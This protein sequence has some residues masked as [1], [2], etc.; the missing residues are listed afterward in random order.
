VQFPDLPTLC[1]V[2]DEAHQ[3]M[4]RGELFSAK[5]EVPTP[6]GFLGL[7]HALPT[8]E[9]LF[10]LDT[11]EDGSLA[12]FTSTENTQFLGAKR[13]RT[14]LVSFSEEDSLVSD[15]FSDFD[16]DLVT[17]DLLS[18]YDSDMSASED[19]ME[20]PKVNT[21]LPRRTKK[22]TQSEESD[23][24]Y[25]VVKEESPT[26]DSPSA[27]QTPAGQKHDNAITSSDDATTPATNQPQSR[28]GRKQSLTEDPSKTFVC[29]L[30]NRRFRR[31]EHLKRHYRSLHTGEKP[32]ECTDCGKKFSRSDN[33][34]QHQRTHGSGSIVMGVLESPHGFGG[35]IVDHAYPPPHEM[36]A[37]MLN[38]ALAAQQNYPSSASS[39]SS[40]SDRESSSSDR[41][42][43]RKRDD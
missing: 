14:E 15:H 29:H 25:S 5:G 24:E 16:E 11:E 42:K 19:T 43:K 17:P 9:P 39:V 6:Q 10:E 4:L 2:D 23:G 40:N 28:R 41:K 12:H 30:C 26:K 21:N 31:Q 7:S 37:I 33:L 3:L 34:S 32:F 35:P 13:Q 38:A 22:S 36:G 8:F 27:P 18:P 20:L 1:P